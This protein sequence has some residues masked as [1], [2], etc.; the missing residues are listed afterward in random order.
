MTHAP[1]PSIGSSSRPRILAHRLDRMP[2][3]GFFVI[4]M[5][6]TFLD[7]IFSLGKQGHK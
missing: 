6:S 3:F 4:L 5:L 1:F 2:F 7:Q